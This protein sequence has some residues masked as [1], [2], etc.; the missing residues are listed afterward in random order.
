MKFCYVDE[1]HQAGEAGGINGG[2]RLTVVVGVVVDAMRMHQTKADWKEFLTN[3]REV[4]GRPVSE[5]K[6]SQLYRGNAAWRGWHG[7]ERRELIDN[8]IDWVVDR[9]HK[10]TFGA[11]SRSKLHSARAQYDLDGLQDGREW[12][13]A[14]MHLVLGIQKQHQRERKNKGHSVFVF[15]R[16]TENENLLGLIL[17]P[18]SATEGFYNRKKKRPPLDQVVDVPYFADSRHVGMIQVAD[19]FA[20]LLCL[21]AGLSE[22]IVGEK[23]E[24]EGARV[25][26]WIQRLSPVLLPDSIRWPQSSSDPC[27]KF[28]RSAAPA[29]LLKLRP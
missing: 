19:L 1:S 13:I 9:K 3:L 11:I 7:D 28:F 5:I 23:Y 24:D 8:I 17:K 20:F 27:V 29:A 6:G 21:H 10:V 4:T 14:A 12:S 25:D 2:D 15:D 26:E 16:A 22:G 18:P